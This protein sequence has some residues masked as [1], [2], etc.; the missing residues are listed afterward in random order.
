MCG[1]S[2][3]PQ[4]IKQASKKDKVTTMC[5]FTFYIHRP[6]DIIFVKNIINLWSLWKY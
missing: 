4:M 3:A 5:T 6:Q 2:S 1:M